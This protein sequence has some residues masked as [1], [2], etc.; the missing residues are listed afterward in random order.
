MPTRSRP[1]VTIVLGAPYHLSSLVLKSGLVSVTAAGREQWEGKEGGREESIR[2]FVLSWPQ[3]ATPAAPS[4][5]H[6]M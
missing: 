6:E 3:A 2:K 1:G 5:G 4:S